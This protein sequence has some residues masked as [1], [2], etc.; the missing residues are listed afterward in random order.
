MRGKAISYGCLLRKVS[1][2]FFFFKESTGSYSYPCFFSHSPWTSV[3]K[4]GATG[5]RV[6]VA[7]NYNMTV[8]V[9][10][11]SAPAPSSEEGRARWNWYSGY[12]GEGCSVISSHPALR[13]PSR[14]RARV[15]VLTGKGRREKSHSGLKENKNDFP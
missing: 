4:A 8:M 7:S 13:Y 9:S 10:A 2:V 11:P 12:L 6:W 15:C 3:G 5:E 1:F 14:A